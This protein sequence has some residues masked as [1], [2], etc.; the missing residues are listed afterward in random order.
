MKIQ[1]I[2]IKILHLQQYLRTNSTL[3]WVRD[4]LA[5]R[6]C[7][8]VKARLDMRWVSVSI[9]VLRELTQLRLQSLHCLV[10]FW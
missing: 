2:A 1:Y 5:V 3:C 8:W 10:S 6:V 7:Y 9:S 4:A